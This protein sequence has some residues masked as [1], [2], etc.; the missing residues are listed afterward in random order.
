MPLS[1]E[2]SL[3]N[4]DVPIVGET[5]RVPVIVVVAVKSVPENVPV[6]PE[7]VVP[8]NEELVIVAPEME[9]A[10]MVGLVNEPPV[11]IELIELEVVLPMLL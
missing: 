6:V 5:V 3:E 4:V 9:P 7:I 8:E 11:V 2:T 10:E 1:N